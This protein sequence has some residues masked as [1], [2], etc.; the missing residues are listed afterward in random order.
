MDVTK[1]H[2]VVNGLHLVCIDG[3]DM[4]VVFV[5]DREKKELVRLSMAD[6]RAYTIFTLGD[7]CELFHAVQKEISRRHWDN[8]DPFEQVLAQV[9]APITVVSG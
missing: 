2:R 9:D 6:G 3:A 1:T 7:F 4:T 8:S 5:R